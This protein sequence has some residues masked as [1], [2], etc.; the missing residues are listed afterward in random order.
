MALFMLIPA[1]SIALLAWPHTGAGLAAVAAI[2][3]ELEISMR[4]ND[5][6]EQRMFLNGK[7]VSTEI[8]LPEISLCASDISALPVVRAYLLEMQRRMAREHS[9]IMDGRDIGTVVLPQ[10]ELKIFLTASA[11]A[12]ALR[13]QRELA[14][15]G[16]P[17]SFE[18]VLRDIQYR[19]EQDTSRAAAPLKRAEDAVLVDTSDIDF[20][21]S[22]ALLESIVEQKLGI[23]KV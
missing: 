12:R 4:Y 1:Q 6:G 17:E 8:R 10:A 3:P 11:E 9:V 22:L 2:L 14:Q 18:E 19:D 20:D 21:A 13:R 15:K 23:K 16:T 7:D 5:A